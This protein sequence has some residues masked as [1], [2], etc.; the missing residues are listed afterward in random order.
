M[1]MPP[2][3]AMFVA[4]GLVLRAAER[5]RAPTHIALGVPGIE[6]TGVEPRVVEAGI[7]ILDGRPLRAALRH[8][9]VGLALVAV[10]R[11]LTAIRI[12]RAD[13]D[14][15]LVAELEHVEGGVA[16]EGPR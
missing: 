2:S 8:H 13:L 10:E 15:S 6:R 5:S 11:Q 7:V 14:A 16:A 9:D 3:T 4:T 12:D 1:R